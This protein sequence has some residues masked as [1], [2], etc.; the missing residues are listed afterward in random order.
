MAKTEKGEQKTY[1]H[2]DKGGEG[3]FLRQED[4]K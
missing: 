1:S 2:T 4:L 3:S